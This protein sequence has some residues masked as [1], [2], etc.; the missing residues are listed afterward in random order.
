MKTP[1]LLSITLLAALLSAC[2]SSGGSGP[3]VGQMPAPPAKPQTE[4]QPE[5][6]P[7]QPEAQPKQPEAQ[8][9]Q[10]E[11][12][13]KPE[14]PTPPA[15]QAVFE[16]LNVRTP[17]EGLGYA[18]LVKL[19]LQAGGK[20]IELQLLQPDNTHFIGQ[21]VVETLRGRDGSL[22]GYYGHARVS[23]I[24]RTPHS[25]EEESTL[26]A[27]LAQD[28]DASRLKRPE[29][30]ARIRYTGSMYYAYNDDRN[31]LKAHVSATYDGANKTLAMRIDGSGNGGSG[32]HTWHLGEHSNTAPKG[33]QNLSVK[34]GD[35]GQVGGILWL[36]TTGGANARLQNNGHFDGGFY[37]DHGEVLTGKAQNDRG[38]AW[39]GVIGATAAQP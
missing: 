12:Q 37:G 1:A 5:A 21:P 18:D 6:Q 28:A 36:D 14:A 4:A 11:A 10:P 16:R 39:Q 20:N 38:E 32:V 19:V 33:S 8:P 7:K 29:G 24:L 23:Q 27:I 13:P 22:I 17:R 9:K 25:N 26:H 2:G 30:M 3:N 31:P 35:G 15:D 34:V